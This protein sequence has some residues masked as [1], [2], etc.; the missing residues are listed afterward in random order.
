MQGPRPV[1]F[2]WGPRVCWESACVVE[3]REM[4]PAKH[5]TEELTRSK[6][7]INGGSS[8]LP[9]SQWREWAGCF[10]GMS[11]CQHHSGKRGWGAGELCGL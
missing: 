11:M 2:A 6:C 4:E 3:M 7:S 9:M 5:L 1:I 8:F 10:L